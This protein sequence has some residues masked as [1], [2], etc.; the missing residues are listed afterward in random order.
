[1]ESLQIL[2]RKDKPA[3]PIGYPIRYY[4]S[5][6]CRDRKWP[7]ANLLFP[8][9]LPQSEML[10]ACFI[11]NRTHHP[12]HSGA[13]Y[14]GQPRVQAGKIQWHHRSTLG[15]SLEVAFRAPSGRSSSC[16][17]RY[18]VAVIRNRSLIVPGV[19]DASSC[20]SITNTS[21]RAASVRHSLRRTLESSQLGIRKL[22]TGGRSR[23]GTKAISFSSEP[24]RCSNGLGKRTGFIWFL[25]ALSQAATR[26]MKASVVYQELHVISCFC[27]VAVCSKINVQ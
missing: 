13:P 2:G 18:R 5:P 14:R 17:H 27:R 23:L 9:V 3:R 1:M 4:R 24:C 8:I 19:T 7:D 11:W 21:R 12:L 6:C 26:R 20:L 15:A 22:V 10:P 25:P 16:L